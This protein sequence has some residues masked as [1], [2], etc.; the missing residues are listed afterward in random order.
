M[1][2][3]RAIPVL[4]ALVLSVAAPCAAAV[5]LPD[6]GLFASVAAQL[7]A[8]EA[9]LATLPAGD[10]GRIALLIGTGR[11]DEAAREA[12]GLPSRGKA[13]ERIARLEAAL[14]VQD[15][16]AAAEAARQLGPET[17]A[18][19]LLYRWDVVRDA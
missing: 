13:A 8:R 4:V 14:A 18:R 12:L 11:A 2:P 16:A 10:A 9:R 7:A 5:A 3:I 15:F 1:S 19:A 6:T 17:Q